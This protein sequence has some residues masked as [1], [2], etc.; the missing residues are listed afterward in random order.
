MQDAEKLEFTEELFKF[1][2]K[3]T[4]PLFYYLQGKTPESEVRK[5]PIKHDDL[6]VWLSSPITSLFIRMSFT[7]VIFSLLQGLPWINL[8]NI[9]QNTVR[10]GLSSSVPN[11][12]L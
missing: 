4:E 6:H 1:S 9:S 12:L 7:M 8:R 10:K 5:Y 3:C 2:V 11:S